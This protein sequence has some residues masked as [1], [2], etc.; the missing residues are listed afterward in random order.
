MLA[1]TYIHGCGIEIGALHK[2]LLLPPNVSVKYVDRLPVAE[3]RKHYTELHTETFVPV[4]ILDDG[5]KLQTVPDASQD[6]I[7]ANHL[8]EH[9]QDPIGALQ[10][11]FRVVKPGGT[12]F[13]AIPDKRFSFDRDRPVTPLQHLIADHREGPE[14]SRETHYWEWVHFVMNMTESQEAQQ[15]FEHL[16]AINYSIHFHVWTQREMLE[17]MSYMRSIFWFNIKAFLEYD[18]ECVFVLQKP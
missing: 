11:F 12:V 13:L 17:F 7:I 4:D 15:T 2:P 18:S 3:L 16:M 9:C 8:L 1:E 10:N 6:F 14:R 5:E